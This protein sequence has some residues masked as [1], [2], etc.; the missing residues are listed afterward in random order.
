MAGKAWPKLGLLVLVG[1]V[2]MAPA[3]VR[4]AAAQQKD[5]SLY[6]SDQFKTVA[7][8]LVAQVSAETLTGACP[9]HDA[10]CERVV[11]RLGEAFGAALSGD[12]AALNGS[13]ND[14]FVESSV[15]AGL[16][17]AGGALVTKDLNAK[18]VAGLKPLFDCV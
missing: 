5:V 17:L 11:A 16:E 13:L 9:K 18:W 6:V 2:L 10:L 12:R 4:A 3:E 15:A 14:F 1:V 8:R 7:K